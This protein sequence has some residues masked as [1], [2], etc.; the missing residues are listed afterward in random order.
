[1]SKTSAKKETRLPTHAV[2]VKT[3]NAST[4]FEQIGVAWE[5]ENGAL[6]VKFY[7]TQIISS[8]VSIFAINREGGDDQE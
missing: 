7:G 2:K 5:N 4:S 1:M 8:P 3:E 6:F